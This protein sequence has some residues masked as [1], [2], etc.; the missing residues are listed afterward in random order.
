MIAGAGN[1]C[2]CTSFLLLCLPHRWRRILFYSESK[3]DCWPP[4]WKLICIWMAAAKLKPRFCLVRF[5]VELFR[6]VHLKHAPL[7]ACP[8]RW[9]ALPTGAQGP[10]HSS[11]LLSFKSDRW[12]WRTANTDDRKATT[13]AG[14][15]LKKAFATNMYEGEQT[16]LNPKMCPYFFLISAF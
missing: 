2:T 14:L 15:I 10:I 13:L 5:H 12:I 6:T 16:M 7:C 9:P 11:S 3:A 1:F 8:H 4:Q